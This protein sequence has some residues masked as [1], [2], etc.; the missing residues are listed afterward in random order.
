MKINIHEESR[1]IIDQLSRNP[2]IREYV[3]TNWEIPRVFAGT[4]QIRLIILGQDPTVTNK[5]SRENMVQVLNLDKEAGALYKYLDGICKSLD[6]NL[7]ENIYATNVIKNFFTD[8]PTEIAKTAGIH[9]LKE[10]APF[11]LP[12][13]QQEIDQLPNVPIIALGEPVLN[14]LVR[15][16]SQSMRD[17]WGFT[18]NWQAGHLKGFTKIEAEN[19]AIHRMI[20]P[21]VHQP[22]QGILFYKCV[23]SLYLNYIKNSISRYEFDFERE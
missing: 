10:A 21:M 23:R 7:K 22:S 14:V 1:N 4:G 12:L 13:L 16:G 9:V 20:F 2:Q 15:N 19:S 17:Y 5:E 18:E 6:L 8:S 3:D 11:W